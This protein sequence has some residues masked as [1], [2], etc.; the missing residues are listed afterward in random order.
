VALDPI[1]PDKAVCFY[2]EMTLG[3]EAELLAFLDKTMI[4]LHG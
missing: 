2:T 1:V 3:E 4:F